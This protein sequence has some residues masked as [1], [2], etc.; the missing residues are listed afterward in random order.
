MISVALFKSQRH[1]A[2]R[3]PPCD[4]VSACR[5]IGVVLTGKPTT[6]DRDWIFVG[7]R[8]TQKFSPFPWVKPGAT[9]LKRTTP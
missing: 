9:P 4:H 5:C 6:A 8:S 7:E 2:V 3:R 1:E